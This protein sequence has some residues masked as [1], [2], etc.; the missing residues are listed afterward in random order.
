M[1]IKSYVENLFALA[2]ALEQN[3]RSKNIICCSGDQVIIVNADSTIL[4]HFK[5]KENLFPGDYSFY[6]NDY[7]SSQFE[8][9]NGK[10]IFISGNEEYE[11]KKSCRTPDMSF[12][13]MNLLYKKMKASLDKCNQ[14]TITSSVKEVLDENLSHVE[15][16][17]QK[18]EFELVQRDIFTGT[19]INV[20]K[21][22]SKGIFQLH[23]DKIIKNTSAIGLRTGD[24]LGL[25]T[26]V[27]KIDFQIS[28][29]GFVYF[30]GD[31]MNMTGFIATCLYDDLGTINYLTEEK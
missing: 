18:G 20:K 27:Q 15:I 5:I 21:K 29:K 16:I 6:A 19:L 12:K 13:K 11:R 3:S 24:F 14:V 4:I 23:S 10:I 30:Q 8:E 9:Q 31:K 7:E 2:V 17:M 1:K 28:D 26:F 22:E 25:F